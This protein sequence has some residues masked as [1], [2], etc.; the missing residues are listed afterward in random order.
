MQT[1]LEFRQQQM[2]KLP[3]GDFLLPYVTPAIFVFHKA[4]FG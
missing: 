1:G 2:T 3:N 4:Y